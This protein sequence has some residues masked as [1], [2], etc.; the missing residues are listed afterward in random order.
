MKKGSE[1]VERIEEIHY[2]LEE[3]EFKIRHQILNNETSA[4]FKKLFK[5]NNVKFQLVPPHVHCLNSEEIAIL[6]F[7]NYF[8]STLFMVYQ[9]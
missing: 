7:K 4:S 2:Y 5:N 6:T 3:R 9:Y 8:I 1:L